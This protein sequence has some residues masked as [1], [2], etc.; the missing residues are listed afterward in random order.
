MLSRTRDTGAVAGRAS[1]IGHSSCVLL[2]SMR[3]LLLRGGRDVLLSLSKGIDSDLD[4]TRVLNNR[5]VPWKT[6]PRSVA[7][8]SYS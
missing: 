4:L 1:V 7:D 3:C 8:L 6:L 2:R 5:V